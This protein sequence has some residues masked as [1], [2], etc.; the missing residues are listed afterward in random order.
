MSYYTEEQIRKIFNKDNGIELLRNIYFDNLIKFSND[1]QLGVSSSSKVSN[2]E[3]VMVYI[4][5]VFKENNI[6]IQDDKLGNDLSIKNTQ[7]WSN[8]NQEI[9][10]HQIQKRKWLKNGGYR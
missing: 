4:E 6:S 7:Y 10:Y 1:K 3:K 5:K 9:R 8:P 2:E